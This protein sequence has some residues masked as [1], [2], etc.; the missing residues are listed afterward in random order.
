MQISPVKTKIEFSV[1]M[2]KLVKQF[3]AEIIGTFIFVTVA[4]GGVAQMVLGGGNHY[5]LFLWVISF[6]ILC[7]KMDFFLKLI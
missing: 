6:F 3:I 2:K 5:E 7:H 1:T 4:L